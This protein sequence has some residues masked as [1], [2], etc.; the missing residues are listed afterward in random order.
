MTNVTGFDF[1]YAASRNVE[2][3]GSVGKVDCDYP[4]E[5]RIRRTRSPML[6]LYRRA[7]IGPIG[8]SFTNFCASGDPRGRGLVA[9]SALAFSEKLPV[10]RA[11]RFRS[12]FRL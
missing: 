4:R 7:F 12:P 10:V 9:D 6:F 1:Q 2:A 8:S 3:G 5:C 11:F